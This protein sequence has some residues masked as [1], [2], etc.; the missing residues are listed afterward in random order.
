MT[1]SVGSTDDMHPNAMHVYLKSIRSHGAADSVS[2]TPLLPTSGGG[3]CA[4][5]DTDEGY[6]GGLTI[7]RPGGRQ[8][9][10]AERRDRGV[11]GEVCLQRDNV[12]Q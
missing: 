2:P 12:S 5:A 10:P 11:T 4:G 7:L 3:A 6:R 9:L 1:S 8:W